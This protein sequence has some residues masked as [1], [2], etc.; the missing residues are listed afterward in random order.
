ML[1]G[2]SCGCHNH[3]YHPNASFFPCKLA[4]ITSFSKQEQQSW[5][6]G[7]LPT[8]SPDYINNKQIMLQEGRESQGDNRDSEWN[9]GAET[10]RLGEFL[11]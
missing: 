10:L 4:R 9:Q 3:W 5:H 11:H 1:Q 2:D 6:E 8:G 7:P